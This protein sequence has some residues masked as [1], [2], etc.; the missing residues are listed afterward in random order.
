M[1]KHNA[2]HNA[3]NKHASMLSGKTSFSY[4]LTLWSLRLSVLLQ[5]VIGIINLV[6][7]QWK[8][9][10]EGALLRS[11]LK[12]DF[13]ITTVELGFYGVLSWLTR[14]RNIFHRHAMTIRYTD[15]SIT[16][17]TMLF[18][19]MVFLSPAQSFG[20]FW[21]T[22]ANLFLLV[23]FLDW[24]MLFC[25]W[26][27]ESTTTEPTKSTSC[28]QRQMWILI[29]FFPL[30]AIFRLLL[31]TFL[32]ELKKHPLKR[33]LLMWFAGLWTL[34]GV[35][36]FASFSVRNTVYNLLDIFSKN[37]TSLFLVILLLP[38]RQSIL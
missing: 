19:L 10:P 6:A 34:Y 14:D 24:C 15:W 9:R 17:P 5:V 37:V 28:C 32:S 33:K 26:R 4:V 36:A 31:L 27:A 8:I 20:G 1:K 11:L 25:G 16:T 12:L 18:S 22:Y 38:Y 35:A 2:K 29:G 21:K 30:C 3:R 7:L 23:T 13:Q